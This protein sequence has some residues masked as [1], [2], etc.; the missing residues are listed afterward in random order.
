M[1]EQNHSCARE[2]EGESQPAITQ[3]ER[4]EK[5]SAQ[6]KRDNLEGMAACMDM[7]RAELI[8]A[9]VIT[10]NVPPMFVAD[11][12]L[13]YIAKLKQEC[14]AIDS[15]QVRDEGAKGNEANS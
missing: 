13:G 8:E 14:A 2:P 9:G 1:E 5:E 12:V 11:A 7:V 15:L 4:D 3:A 6:I 10:D